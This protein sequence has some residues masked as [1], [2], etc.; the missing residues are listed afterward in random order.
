MVDEVDPPSSG[1]AVETRMA[2][3]TR[4]SRAGSVAGPS[5]STANDDVQTS[6]IHHLEERLDKMNQSQLEMQAQL[7]QTL[8]D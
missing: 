6:R 2:K 1:P 4:Q 3:R 7:Q 5:S 8:A